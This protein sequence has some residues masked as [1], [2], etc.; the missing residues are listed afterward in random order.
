MANSTELEDRIDEFA[1]KLAEAF[2]ELTESDEPL[3][4]QIRRIG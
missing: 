4:T 3:I 2:G 1:R